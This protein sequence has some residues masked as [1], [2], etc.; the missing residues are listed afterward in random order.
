[1]AKSL[2]NDLPGRVP[3]PGV[4]GFTENRLERFQQLPVRKITVK[5]GCPGKFNSE[6]NVGIH[7]ITG[8]DTCFLG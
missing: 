1:M 2:K 4:L 6:T 8:N 7:F 5:P 3:L